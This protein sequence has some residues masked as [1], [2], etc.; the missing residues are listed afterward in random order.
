VSEKITI[1]SILAEMHQVVSDGLVVSPGQW[2][3][4]AMNLSALWQDL[5]DEKT[6]AEIEFIRKVNMIQEEQD[7][8]NA[9]AVTLTKGRPPNESGMNEYQLFKYLEGRDKIVKE[10]IMLAKKRATIEEI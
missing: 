4:W 5:I 3:N 8:S 1:K 9:K 6:K 2:L 7:C 10:L